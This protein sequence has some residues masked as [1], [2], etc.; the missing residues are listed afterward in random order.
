[1][2]K[3]LD[4]KL[5]DLE[6]NFGLKKA[7]SQK[8]VETIRTGI[9]ALDYVLDGIKLCEG[10]H[11]IEFF[12]NESSGKTTFALKVVKRFQELGKTC[13]WIVSE[14][15]HDEWAK[16]L[17][18]DTDKLLLA[19]PESVEDATETI[20]GILNQ[21]DLVVIDSVASLIPEAEAE[22][23]MHEQ[24]RGL[25]AKAY[26]QFCRKLYQIMAH[27]TTTL[28]CINQI[29]EKMGVIY[30]NPETTPCG[31]AL[32]FMYDTRIEFRAGSA[33]ENKIKET[34]KKF[35]RIGMEI[36]LFGKKNKLGKA[37]RRSVLDFYFKDGTV[38]TKKN[39]IFAGI[40]YSIIDFAGKTYKYKKKKAVGKAKFIKVLTDE[41]YKNIEEEVWE[42]LK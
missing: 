7:S 16:Q 26:S 41:D 28:I 12:G 33:I 19:Y 30:G 27:E 18:V 23:T 5:K 2:G 21:A 34:E 37:H 14:S 17:G 40:K 24:T 39:L 3:D 6:K 32:K 20:L 13:V 38:D 8:E 42:R 29:R 31:R 36:N 35:E 1:M 11:K 4:K 10:G 25:Q 9:Y 22:K 15:F